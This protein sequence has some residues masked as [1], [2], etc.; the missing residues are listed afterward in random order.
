[1]PLIYNLERLPSTGH[2]RDFVSLDQEL[3]AALRAFELI[4]ANPN[5]FVKGFGRGA[6]LR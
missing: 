4:R 1:M 2:A 3:F 5:G 6:Q